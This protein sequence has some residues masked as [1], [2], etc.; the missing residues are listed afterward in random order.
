[1]ALDMDHVYVSFTDY[2]WAHYVIA[3]NAAFLWLS[4]ILT[5]FA[6]QRLQ[7]W[8]LISAKP[9]EPARVVALLLLEGVGMLP[10]YAGKKEA[11]GKT[12]ASF[13]WKDYPMLSNDGDFET[14]E[15]LTIDVD[16]D[17]KIMVEALLNDEKIT[18]SDAMTLVWFNTVFAAHV[19]SHS[20]ANWVY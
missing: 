9:C 2:V 19:K 12:L 13:K 3:P 20:Y 5:L 14:A 1:M 4:G 10:H 15:S 6:R 7:R 18:A 17:G 8:G 11:G 16:L